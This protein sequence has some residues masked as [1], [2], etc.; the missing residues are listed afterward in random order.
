MELKVYDWEFFERGKMWYII[1]ACVILL[2]AVLSVLSNNVVWWV[3]V[4]LFASGYLY[5]S[6]K[7]NKTTKM[8]IWKKVLEVWKTIYQWE[9]L[10]WFVLEYHTKKRKIHNIVIIDNKNDPKIYTINDTAKNIESF[11]NE[12]NGYIP[13]LET[14]PQSSFDKFVRK[15]KL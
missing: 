5:F 11:V 1:F 7:S 8:I 13:M 3:I 2:V 15:L 9:T 10:K 6:L 12:L 14:Y 4:L